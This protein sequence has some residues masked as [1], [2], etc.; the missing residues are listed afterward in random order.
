MSSLSRYGKSAIDKTY[1]DAEESVFGHMV[2][3]LGMSPEQAVQ[4]LRPWVRDLDRSATMSKNTCYGATAIGAGVGLLVGATM[5]VGIVAAL[6]IVAA[7]YSFLLAQQSAKEQTTREAEYLLLKSC[8][9]LLKLIYALTKRGLPKEALI[10]CYDELLGSFTAHH[11]SRA[12]LGVSDELDH[13]IVRSFQEIVNRKCEA[14]NLGRQIVSEAQDF[15]FDTLYQS[16]EPSA[17]RVE[18]PQASPAPIG[19]QTRLGAVEVSATSEQPFTIP[20]VSPESK[21]FEWTLLNTAYDDFPHL[22]M[23]GKTGA[24][25]SFLAEY[26]GRFLNGS[27]IVITPKKKPKDFIGMQV[28]GV[29]YDFATIAANIGGLSKLVKDREAEMNQTGKEDFLPI[30]VILDEVPTFVAGCNDLKLDVVKDL[31]FII[32]AGRTSK[33]RLILLA[34]GQEVK[35]LGIEGEGSLRDNLSYVYL[36]GFAEKQA[37]DLKLD[38]ST[39]DR[40]CIID[41]KVAEIAAL[42]ELANQKL[43]EKPPIASTPEALDRM[44]RMESEEPKALDHEVEESVRETDSVLP[45][46]QA[47]F[48][49]WKPKSIEVASTIVDWLAAR[50]DKSFAPYEIRK[51]IRRLKDDSSLPTEKIK[52]VLDVLVTAQFLL[53]S[54]GKYSITP[55]APNTEEYDF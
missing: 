4:N 3:E 12:V 37:Q 44:Y 15:R 27:T 18:R 43:S 2:L 31:K 53:E 22:L 16:S 6:P 23:L 47:A 11:Q 25:K 19:N 24:G 26:L 5:G 36:K 48:P 20:I 34:Q 49:Q 41:S 17:P 46:I 14:E 51:S 30:N 28:I 40:P 55:N 13:D 7:G 10:E 52:T 45:K 54:E 32:R 33:V 39:Y 29:P 21:L 9:E 1:P 42:L 8:P 35:T 38:I 50:S